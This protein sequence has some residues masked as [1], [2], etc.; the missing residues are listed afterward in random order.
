MTVSTTITKQEFTCNGAT[1]HFALTFKF[2]YDT[3]LLIKVRSATTGLTTTLT[4]GSHYDVTAENTKYESGGTVNTFEYINGVKTD[5][6]YSADYTLIVERVTPLTQLTQYVN[7]RAL[8]QENIGRDL[9]KLILIMQELKDYLNKSIHA[10]VDDDGTSYELPVALTRASKYLFFDAAG[11]PG[12]AAGVT[13]S[14]VTVSAFG[15]TLVAAANA[16]AA[17]ILLGA[18][19]AS[20]AESVAGTATDKVISPATL[21]AAIQSGTMHYAAAAGTNTYTATVIPN[22]TSYVEG[23]FYFLKFTN[24]NTVTNPTLNLNG[25]GAKT[26]V[27]HANAA[28]LAGDIPAG[29]RHLFQYEGGYMVLFNPYN[30]AV[31]SIPDGSI[32]DTQIVATGISRIADDAVTTV[33]I[34]NGNVTA[35]KIADSAV[36]ET[37]LAAS[38]VAQA[39]LKTS[40]GEVSTTAYSNPANLT[41]PGGEYGFYPQVKSSEANQSV[42]AYISYGLV[43]GSY[44]TN[45]GLQSAQTYTAYAQQRYVTSSGEVTWL[46]ILRDKITKAVKSSW[47]ASDHPCMGNGGDPDIIQHPF[48]DYNATTDE[49]ICINPSR[50]EIAEING[51]IPKGGSLLQTI[52]ETYE[53]DAK[54]DKPWPTQSVT[55]GLPEGYDWKMA[56]SGVDV[57]P[58]KAVIPQPSNIFCRSLISKIETIKEVIVK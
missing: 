1:H 52:N 46:F 16:A 14:D 11:N 53:V 42:T 7:N 3:D 33:R 18:S 10:P 27:K 37:K 31:A 8:N 22:I 28:L 50:A 20:A 17:L 5:K 51:K 48:P 9:D 38:A 29:G 55:V 39:K 40:T 44:I 21:S 23:A 24:A 54:V 15:E 19:Y 36:T 47:I 45:I 43:S 13:P 34:L 6:D 57:T 4:L 32:T 56:Q 12:A 30:T 58:V 35:G 26:I 25:L 2:L 49:I 41:L